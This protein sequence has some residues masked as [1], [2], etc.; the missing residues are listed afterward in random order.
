M[1]V[2]ESGMP[3]ATYWHSFFDPPSLLKV[4]LPPIRSM[5]ILEFGSGYGT[6]TLPLAELGHEVTAL[7]IESELV[8]SLR[9]QASSHGLPNLGAFTRDFVA[10]GTGE[11]AKNF[12]HVLLYNI[13]H[14]E[15]PVSLLQEALRIL[16]PGATAS[17]IHWRR[18]IETPRGP[19]LAIRPNVE[20]C[21]AWGLGAGFSKAQPVSPG[22][23]APYHYGLILTK[24]H[25]DLGP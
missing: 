9:G 22:A 1:K 19:S 21:A 12:D 5:R 14:I 2:R 18:D 23:A 3:E 10:D 7:D 13:L 17:I 16:K 11:P 20:Q 4:L 6:F 25:R 24:A 8:E 15:E